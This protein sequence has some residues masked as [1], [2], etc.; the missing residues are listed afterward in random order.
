MK[1]GW[2]FRRYPFPVS[3]QTKAASLQ[4]HTNHVYEPP[5][6]TRSLD[7]YCLV[8]RRMRLT[9][10]TYPLLKPEDSITFL[11]QAETPLCY[12]ILKSPVG[13]MDLLIW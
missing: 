9:N 6:W 11:H 1:V 12:L 7:V 8:M 2:W 5:P 10:R 3:F 13:S 4:L